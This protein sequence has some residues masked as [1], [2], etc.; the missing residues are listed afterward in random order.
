MN[1]IIILYLRM[2]WYLEN[3]FKG[4]LI[5]STRIEKKKWENLIIQLI[6]L[7]FDQKVMMSLI[8]ASSELLFYLILPIFDEQNELFTCILEVQDQLKVQISELEIF[9]SPKSKLFE[10]QCFFI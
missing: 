8:R 5:S 7:I 1:F 4:V 3:C 10:S 6:N 9:S 2:F